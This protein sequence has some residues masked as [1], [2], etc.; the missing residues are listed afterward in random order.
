MAKVILDL[1]A[2]EIKGLLFQLPP[3]DLLSLMEELEERVQTLEMMQLAETGFREWD[4]A[5]EDIYDVQTQS[6]A[7]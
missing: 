2:D 3:A 5:G 1:T 4:E 6:E 7:Q